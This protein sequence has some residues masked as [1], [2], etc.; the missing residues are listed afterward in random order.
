MA[1]GIYVGLTAALNMIR[2]IFFYSTYSYIRTV[3]L[4][5]LAQYG[6]G[7]ATISR[8]LNMIGFFCKRAL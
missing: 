1:V 6:Y 5:Q 3:Q 4:A 8:L 2:T 7:M